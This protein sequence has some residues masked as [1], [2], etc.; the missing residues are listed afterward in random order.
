MRMLPIPELCPQTQ[1]PAHE[2]KGQKAEEED[3]FTDAQKISYHGGHQGKR[4]GK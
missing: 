4:F 1:N 3:S 2:S